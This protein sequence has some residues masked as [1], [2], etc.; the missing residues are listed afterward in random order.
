MVANIDLGSNKEYVVNYSDF[1]DN[2]K[3][4]NDYD[5]S[6]FASANTNVE[7][8]SAKLDS[9]KDEQGCI[10]KAWNG[11]K[12]ATGLGVSDKD[13]EEAIEKFKKG[14]ISYEEASKKIDEF[15]NKQDSSLNLFSNIATSVVA[16]AA[17]TAAGAA[18]V[19]SGGT[20]AIPILA[21]VGAGSGAAAKIGFK[22]SDRATNEVEGDALNGK[23]ILKDGLSGAVTGS[24]AAA[25]MGTGSSSSTL[26]SSMAKSA[27]RSMKTGAVTGAISGSSNYAIDCAFDENKDFKVSEMAKVAVQNAATTA[28]VGGIIG[29]TNGALRY[30][31]KLNS[32]GMVKA[33]A[34]T[35]INAS[36]DDIIANSACSGAYKIG[37]DRVKAL[38]S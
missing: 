26:A 29:S 15:K 24:I 23:Q 10:S 31:G 22:M 6:I 28:V 1:A 21:A 11:F 35:V 19:A 36:S 30:T 17:A 2:S 32:G 38:A 25:T 5:K 18:I 8:L 3:T 27:T 13:C 16:I 33:D 34:G 7:D 12:N 4:V 14:E 37:S 9:V 20:A